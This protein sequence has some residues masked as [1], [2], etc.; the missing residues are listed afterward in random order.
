[1]PARKEPLISGHVYHVFNKSL[2]SRKTFSSDKNCRLMLELMEYYRSGKVLPSFS[3]TR[4]IKDPIRKSKIIQQISVIR[5]FRVDIIAYCLM[6]NHFHLLLRQK[7]DDGISNYLSDMINSFTRNYNMRAQRKGPLF[8]P[9]FQANRIISAE[10]LIHTSRYIHLNPFA[11]GV[12][13]D[14][15]ELVSY[16]WSS[17]HEYIQKKSK[18]LTNSKSILSE[19]SNNR[20]EYKKFVLERADYQR[21]IEHLKH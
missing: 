16:P 6:P 3:R 11:S 1:M 19:F 18:P 12:V 13:S 9:R 17:L 7:M 4:D 8:L 10:Q 14:I 2:D 5:Y 15:S 20:D 21:S